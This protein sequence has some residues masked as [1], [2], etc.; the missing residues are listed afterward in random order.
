M[1]FPRRHSLAAVPSWQRLPLLSLDLDFT[2]TPN[3]TFNLMVNRFVSWFIAVQVLTETF[4][5]NPLLTEGNTPENQ[6][7]TQLLHST[8]LEN[9]VGVTWNRWRSSRSD[10][11]LRRTVPQRD[12]LDYFFN[13]FLCRPNLEDIIGYATNSVNSVDVLCRAFTRAYLSKYGKLS[14]LLEF[15]SNRWETIVKQDMDRFLSST[16]GFLSYLPAVPPDRVLD[17]REVVEWLVG[18]LP[19]SQTKLSEVTFV[20]VRPSL[21]GS[22]DWLFG[23]LRRYGRNGSLTGN[24]GEW[25]MS[26]ADGG[27]DTS[28]SRV[29]SLPF[30]NYLPLANPATLAAAT[31]FKYAATKAGSMIWSMPE[32][33]VSTG[34]ELI[35]DWVRHISVDIF[36]GKPQYEVV[37]AKHGMPRRVIARV[38]PKEESAPMRIKDLLSKFNEITLENTRGLSGRLSFEDHFRSGL[39]L[40]GVKERGVPVSFLR[41]GRGMADRA[42]SDRH[43]PRPATPENREDAEIA[44]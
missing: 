36:G 2:Q 6:G 33:Q 19:W 23:N 13:P 35:P 32:N 14:P 22:S 43:Q 8:D 38:I 16:G 1:T 37:Q 25:I 20:P 7:T 9:H 39:C 4:S 10:L 26:L 17:E 31:Q 15:L 28:P 42:W 12:Y 11:F 29:S 44:F 18:E 24:S 41:H 27:V 21:R 40:F 30:Q 3:R 5:V 34:L